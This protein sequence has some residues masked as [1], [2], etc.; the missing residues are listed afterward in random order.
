VGN[1]TLRVVS[2]MVLAVGVMVAAA[3][4]I[5][6]G[7]SEYR[8][9]VQD[10]RTVLAAAPP[11]AAEPTPAGVRIEDWY[12]AAG[13]QFLAGLALLVVGSITARIAI[14]RERHGA[15]GAAN[16][17]FED[18]LERLAAAVGA[19]EQSLDVETME[20]SKIELERI[21]GELVLPM[22]EARAGLTRRFGL[23]GAVAVLSPLSGAERLI[24]RSWSA[25]VD[26]HVPES[27]ASLAGASA[28]LRV[29]R[30]AFSAS[31]RPRPPP[32]QESP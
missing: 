23:A 11:A 18:S 26:H 28:E 1:G 24:N 8:V 30:E 21:S 29:A 5:R 19:L 15:S 14:N 6:L 25:L 9:F 3:A 2:T 27:R 20:Q 4:G 22:I 10:G 7:A 13:G 32:V 31:S 17:D 12:A 16:H